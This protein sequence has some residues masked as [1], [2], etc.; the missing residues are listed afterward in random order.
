MNRTTNSLTLLAALAVLLPAGGPLLGGT[1]NTF[2]FTGGV[3]NDFFNELNWTENANGTGANPVGDPIMD[4]ATNAITLDLIIDGDSVIANGQ[5]DFGTGSLTLEAGS[6]LA[7][8]GPGN[9]LDIN[10]D[11]TFSLSDAAIVVDD[12]I[13]F[14]GDSSFSGGSVVSLT[15]D[16]AFQDNFVNLSIDGTSFVAADNIYFDGF[17]GSIANASFNSA[18]RFGVRNNVAIVMSDTDIV[19]ESG[20]GDIDDVFG[21]AGA[22]SSLTLLGASNLVADSVEEGADL[23]LGGSTIAIMGGQGARI[24]ADGSTITMDTMEAIL[25]VQPLDSGDA[26]FV[27]A[28]PFLINGIT[29]LSYA[30]DPSTWNVKN[31]NGSDLVTLQIVPEPTG[32]LLTMG[33]LLLLAVRRTH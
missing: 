20:T 29:G 26:D 33:A 25:V 17:T 5:V 12:V 16:V 19:V 10:A 24:V 11:S 6:V 1:L 8:A 3:N 13:N 23:I 4:S 9:D 15:D 7:V 14:E 27:D 31:W 30:A 2:F 22:G 21:A 28:R 18:D 32:L